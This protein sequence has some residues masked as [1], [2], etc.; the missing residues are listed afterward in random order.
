MSYTLVACFTLFLSTG[1]VRTTNVNQSCQQGTCPCSSVNH[2]QTAIDSLQ[3]EADKLKRN[4]VSEPTGPCGKDVIAYYPFDR[5]YRDVCFGYNGVK[6]GIVSLH[7]TSGVRQG[8][9]FFASQGKIRVARLNGYIWGSQFAVSLWFKRT[10][11]KSTYQGL[12]NNGYYSHGSWE[13][14]M[15]REQNGQMLGGGVITKNSKPKTWNY[16][17]LKA[18]F[19]HWHHV[20]MTYNGN[21]L[22]FYLDNVKQKG[23][24]SCCQGNILT[25]K[26]DVVIG[27]AGHGSAREFFHGFIDEVKLFKKALSPNEVQKLYQLKNV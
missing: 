22:D 1:S 10:G 5:S 15:G 24:S 19:D 12:V 6:E 27:Q 7:S 18:S 26:T 3:V 20:V 14:R 2:L 4:C 23:K 8:A 11:S 16:V 13:I 25:K 17:G 9:A 21:T